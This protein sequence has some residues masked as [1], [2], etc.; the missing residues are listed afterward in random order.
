MHCVFPGKRDGALRR[1]EGIRPPAGRPGRTKRVV[2]R[3]DIR[4]RDTQP[5]A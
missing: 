5:C 1:R 3:A 2:L 4:T